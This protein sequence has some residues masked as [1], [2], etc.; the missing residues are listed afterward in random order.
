[1]AEAIILCGGMLEEDFILPYLAEREKKKDE[2]VPFVIAADRGLFFLREHAFVPDLVVG[3]FD[4]APRGLIDRFREEHPEVEVRTYNPR[5]DLTDGEIAA[6]AAL[7][8]GYKKIV[9]LGCTGGRV[10]HLLGNLQL[11]ARIQ[12]EGGS[13]TILDSGN[14][15]TLH[16]RPFSILRKEQWGN[17][18]S[19]FAFGGPCEGL[20]LL[21]FRYPVRDL[22]LGSVGTLT[23]SNQIEAEEGRV[24]FRSGSLLM[25]EASDS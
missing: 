2:P 3:D 24:S 12:E 25:V 23:V 9:L 6:M 7:E 19:F 22:D 16:H 21:G 18:V 1:M 4:S 13:G 14:R 10:D 8:R 20:S 15:I 5:K 11:L 17:Y